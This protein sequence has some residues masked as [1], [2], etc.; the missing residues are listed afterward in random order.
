MSAASPGS[1]R[2][3]GK[4]ATHQLIVRSASRLIR[5]AGLTAASVPRVMGGAGLTVGGFYAHF[6]SKRAM[7]AEVLAGMLEDVRN[8]WFKDIDDRPDVAGL[9]RAVR[10]YLSASHRDD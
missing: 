7:D 2:A 4:A 6:R 10:R 1:R 8:R 5:R 9:A 3:R